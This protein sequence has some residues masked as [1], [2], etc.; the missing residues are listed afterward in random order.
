MPALRRS[1]WLLSALLVAPL[2]HPS[3][4]QAMVDASAQAR[5]QPGMTKAEVQAALGAPQRN[6]HIG[7][8]G[9]DVWRYTTPKFET[10][11]EVGFNKEGRVVTAQPVWVPPF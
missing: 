10:W 4:A 5:V 6:R 2:L 1:A 7:R 3:A 8:T 11:F 9:E